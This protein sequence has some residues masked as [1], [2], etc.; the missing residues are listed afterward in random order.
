M[1]HDE[2]SVTLESLVEMKHHN[3]A[4]LFCNFLISQKIPAKVQPEGNGFIIY[5]DIEQKD[6]AKAIFEDFIKN[7]HH[8]QYQQAAWNNGVVA[9]IKDNSPSILVQFKKQFLRHAGI[10]TLSIFAVCWVFFLLSLLGFNNTI[11]NE[12]SFFHQLTMSN[13]IEQPYR[14]IGP[15]FFHF[16]W[17]HIVFNTMWWWQIGG[18][19]ERTLGKGSLINLFVISAVISN[20]GQ[21]LVSGPNFGGL[22]GV[23]YALFGYIWWYG[24]LAPEKG[25]TISKPIIGFLMF[26]MLLG[27]ADVLP[28]NMA[29]TAH[30]LGLVSG[31]G[32]AWFKIKIAKHS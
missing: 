13:L 12:V 1:S 24:W 16:S 17:L 22:S 14:L 15:A 25:L 9:D 29:N 6:K 7:P 21:F 30:L 18:Q 2:T 27:F 10:V 31:C 4:L 3:I 32:L 19:I 28:V 5:C 20:L 26:F 23:V 8:P 11:F